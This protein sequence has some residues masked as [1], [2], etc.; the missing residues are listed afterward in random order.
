MTAHEL[1]HALGLPHRQNL[2]ASGTTG[3]ILNQAEVDR[4]RSRASA[5]PGTATVPDLRRRLDEATVQSHAAILR[6]SRVVKWLLERH[7]R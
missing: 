7:M 6:G 4:V 3:T 1:G 2:L 5:I